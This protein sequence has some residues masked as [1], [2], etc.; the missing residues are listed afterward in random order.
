MNTLEFIK[1]DLSKTAIIVLV[2]I[3]LKAYL[4]NFISKYIH[5]ATLGTF[6]AYLLEFIS[7]F[8][9]IYILDKLLKKI[10]KLP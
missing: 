8:L 10:F 7:L 4:S 5:F 9:I 3:F 6:G 1:K 2:I